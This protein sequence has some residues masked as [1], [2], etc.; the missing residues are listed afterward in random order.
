MCVFPRPST[1]LLAGAGL[2][3]TLLALATPGLAAAPAPAPAGT[4]PVRIVPYEVRYRVSLQH[5]E[6]RAGLVVA[7]GVLTS[8]L[9]GSACAGWSS[10]SGMRVRFVF[11]RE[12]VRETESRVTSWESDDGNQFVSRIERLLNG[13]PIERIRVSV[14]RSGPGLPFHLRMRLPEKRNATL[15]ASTLFPTAALKKILRAAMNGTPG[16]TMLLYEG[17]E[18]TSPQHVV[19]TIGRR[20]APLAQAGSDGSETAASPTPAPL[21][22]LAYWPVSLAYYGAV[23]RADGSTPTDKQREAARFG[24]PEYE[25]HFRL[26]EN[27]ISGN[28]TLVYPD[29]VLKAT[30]HDLKLLPPEKCD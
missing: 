9:A 22:G 23:T 6:D 13:A 11:R 5:A 15:P 30:V 12:G 28:A 17:D 29:Y 20:H 8:R 21:R 18:E 19:A 7:D 24:L 26:Y 27:G 3:A 25:V 4:A 2:A 1:S 14:E 16:L 10:T